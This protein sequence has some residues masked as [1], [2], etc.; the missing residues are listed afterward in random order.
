MAGSSPCFKISLSFLSK[1]GNTQFISGYTYIHT[2]RH[3]CADTKCPAQCQTRSRYIMAACKCCYD[4]GD[5][6]LGLCL[7]CSRKT[8]HL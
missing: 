5:F 2:Y 7:I 8:L 1:K 4:S 3:T 6:P